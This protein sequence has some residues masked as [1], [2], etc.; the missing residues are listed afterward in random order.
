MSIEAAKKTG[1]KAL[2]DEKYGNIVRVL[3]IK[4][5]STELCGG[6]HVSRTGD[7][8]LIK[9]I[10]EEGIG[11]G[12]RRINA[13]AGLPA[14]KMVQK[15]SNAFGLMLNMLGEDVDT[16]TSKIEDMLDEKKV[17]ERKNRELQV[18][19]AMSN[20]ENTVK[21]IVSHKG[22]DFILESFEDITPELLRQVGD[23]IRQKYPV[24]VI[25]LV[26]IGEAK[27]VSLIA[28]SS[29]DA[30]KKGAHSGKILKEIASIM[31]GKGG[32]TPSLAQG[33]APNADKFKNAL[34]KAPEIFTELIGE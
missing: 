21:P 8:G 19:V 22:V 32:G 18:K 16:I 3:D 2:F 28:M 23:R 12:L 15:T 29:D 5:Y 30:I 31:D 26:G 27:K 33:G 1:A 7:I 13:L 9:I 14:L 17:L 4:D 25:L 24:S 10:R 20:I 34:E 11:S 6:T